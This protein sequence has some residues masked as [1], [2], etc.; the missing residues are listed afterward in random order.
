M[1]ARFDLDAQGDMRARSDS[2]TASYVPA[3]EHPLPGAVSRGQRRSR[4]GADAMEVARAVGELGCGLRG[5]EAV[6]TVTTVVVGLR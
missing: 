5:P 3:V 1:S 6:A 2:V 4:S